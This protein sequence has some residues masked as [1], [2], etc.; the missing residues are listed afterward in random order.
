MLKLFDPEN[1]FWNFISKI[2]DVFCISLLWMICSLPIF[3]I[4]A[5]TAALY[6]FTLHLVYD[7]ED[8]VLHGFF[9]PFKSNFKKATV[10]WL[11]QLAAGLF[12]AADC[13]LAWQFF[14]R[15]PGFAGIMVTAVVGFVTLIYVMASF[16]IYPLLVTFDFPIKKLIRDSAVIAVTRLFHTAAI[17]L[18][19]A[20]AAAA[21]YFV[22]GAF[23]VII[24][25]AA[26]FSSYFI[27]AALLSCTNEE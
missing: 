25:L 19:W 5:A 9:T 27:R 26:F 18:V 16:Y 24:G 10:V 17:L 8:T 23:F 11:V 20:A 21:L 6:S 3:T 22:S 1:R 4:G 7:A 2:A 13:F 14:I 12:L 15:N